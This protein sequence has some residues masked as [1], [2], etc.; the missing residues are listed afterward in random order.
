MSLGALGIDGGLDQTF[1]LGTLSGSPEFAFPIYLEHSLRVADP[2]SEYKINQL[3]SYVVPEGREEVLWVQPGGMRTVFKRSEILKTEPEEVEEDWVAVER[4]PLSYDFLSSDGWRYRYEQGALHSLRS[5]SGRQ[6]FFETSGILISR[7]YQQTD[8]REV[9]LLTAKENDLGQPEEVVI[10]PVTHRFQYEGEQDLLAQWQAS[11]TGYQAVNFSYNED[12]LVSSIDFPGGDKLTYTWGGRDGAWQSGVNWKLPQEGAGWFLAQDDHY[13]YRYGISKEGINLSRTDPADFTD[14]FVYNPRTQKMVIKNRDGGEVTRFYGVRGEEYGRLESVRDPRG[15]EAVSLSY[16]EEGRVKTRKVPGAAP[17]RYEYDDQGRLDK[18]YRLEELNQK[19]EYEGDSQKPSV[20]TNALG[21][22]IRIHY[23][24][25]GQV[26]RYQTLDGAVY[27]YEYDDLGQLVVE[28]WPMGYQRS[29]ERDEFNRVVKRIHLDG[30][31]TIYDYTGEN[32][33]ASTQ[34][35]GKKWDYQYDESGMLAQLNRDG[36]M[37]QKIER[38]KLAG[39]DGEVVKRIRADGKTSS[40]QLDAHGNV[41]KEI[42]PLGNTTE[43]Q[44]DELGQ[45]AG[46]KDGR[47]V[48]AEFERDAFGRVSEVE[49]EGVKPLSMAYDQTGRLTRRKTGEQDIQYRYNREGQLSQIDYGKGET[50]DYQYDKYG[51][52]LV[53]TTSQGVKT[54]YTWDALDRKISERND[55]PGGVWTLVKWEYTPGSR[56]AMVAVYQNGDDLEHRLQE[57]RY[58]YDLLGRYAGI[59]VNGEQKIWYDYE[60]KSR[61]LARK[62][63]ANGWTIDY[64]HHSDGRPASILA[65]DD[66]G[67]VIKDV[68]YE[69]GD[70]GKL[71]SRVLDGVL[72]EY[73]YDQLGRLT[74]VEK[75]KIAQ[76]AK[77]EGH[78]AP[79]N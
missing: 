65:K 38:E 36:E 3:E 39:M 79:L 44:H 71:A 41:K 58:Q 61:Q 27:E 23:N 74:A 55:I 29:I 35:G 45:L 19:F 52:I 6:L 13:R 31:E 26:T 47:G 18:V 34:Q 4:A 60:P 49:T 66:K 73:Q 15:R 72:H 63:F 64:G 67:Q 54:T 11:T 21:D 69:W 51:R 1:Y 46:W 57:T 42:D 76:K 8:A 28:K 33:L 68:T 77:A 40:Y 24:E 59:F 17:L 25:A 70:D 22:S 56:K 78:K 62:R 30:S 37:W 9:T 50:I 53:A 14:G 75:R 20:I 32:R 7:I 2:V 48:V 16:D 10:G 5:P 43:Y 12:F